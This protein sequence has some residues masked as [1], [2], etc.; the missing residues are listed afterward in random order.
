MFA[1]EK[2]K[3]S[4]WQKDLKFGIIFHND[5]FY[6][7]M[8]AFFEI[9]PTFDFMKREVRFQQ[10]EMRICKHMVTMATRKIIFTKSLH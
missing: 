5:V 2:F 9:Q 1:A 8:R 3:G 4:S 10:R 6:N 7:L